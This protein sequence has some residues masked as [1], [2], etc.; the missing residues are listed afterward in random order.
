MRHPALSVYSQAL[1][2][3]AQELWPDLQKSGERIMPGFYPLLAADKGDIATDFCLVVAERIRRSPGEIARMLRDRLPVEIGQSCCLSEQSFG[4]YLAEDVCLELLKSPVT[5]DE[6]SGSLEH[7][8]FVP[9][10]STALC[11]WAHFRLA[12]AACLQFLML[13]SLGERARLF[14]GKTELCGAE[15]PSAGSLVRRLLALSCDVSAL[16]SRVATMEAAT[17]SLSAAA[18]A[19]VHLW[20]STDSIERGS[21]RRLMHEA[22][23]RSLRLQTICPPHTWF[24][25]YEEE[26][27]LPA[28]A[29]WSDRDLSAL[30]YYLPGSAAALNLDLQIARFHEK[31]NLLWFLETTCRRLGRVDFPRYEQAVEKLQLDPQTKTLMLKT[32]FLPVFYARAAW[33]AAPWEYLTAL[34]DLLGCANRFMNNPVSRRDLNIAQTGSGSLYPLARVE[35]ALR[36]VIS[37]CL[38]IRG[39][40][41]L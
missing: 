26:S 14:A 38:V 22:R 35:K 17:H 19:L 5:A 16:E 32:C 25:H 2:A 30:L 33:K 15:V 21:F 37:L 8:V 13:R 34:S 31:E 28:L 29:G 6:A 11:G 12:L 41:I 23:T 20:L 18:Q 4:F 39:A 9:L 1:C 10:P 7:I 36:A 24:A 40:K 3:A 27:E